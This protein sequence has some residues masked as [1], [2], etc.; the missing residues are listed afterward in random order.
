M[1]V[2]AQRAA[3]SERTF[4]RRFAA[5]TGTT[6]GKWLLAQR[7]HHARTLLESTDLAVETVA[8]RAGFGSAALLRHHFG[9]R[10]A[11]HRRS[12]GVRSAPRTCAPA[13]RRAPLR[14]G[15]MTYPPA[16]WNMHG[17][18]WLSLFRV[19][20]GD[21]PDRPAGVYGAA[22]VSYERPSPLT[23]SE[24]LVAR[25]VGEEGHH[26]RHLG[27]L[28]RLARRRSRP[29]GD[30][31]GP[32]RL[33]PRQRPARRC[34][35]RRGPPASRAV[36]SPG[37]GSPTSPT[38]RCARRSRARPQQE[39]ESG[40][41]GRRHAHGQRQG[42]ALPRPLG[43]QRRRAARL[44]GRQAAP[45]VVPDGRLSDV[46]RLILA[47]DPRSRRPR[48]DSAPPRRRPRGRG[49]RG[50]S[51]SRISNSSV[52]KP[53]IARPM[54]PTAPVMIVVTVPTVCV[55]AVKVSCTASLRISAWLSL[56]RSGPVS[57]GQVSLRP[58]T[59]RQPG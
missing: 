31:E 38:R 35:A 11:W 32:V 48:V 49:R 47:V 50:G 8:S 1:R 23:Y 22:L 34:S 7:L 17:Q 27:G 56:S 25:P 29:L 43:V 2:L 5:E 21:H 9:T 13:E 14:L 55:A 45:R 30:P 26:H 42:A 20:E 12:T 10:S 3:M 19:R 16:P 4:A 54:S 40:E 6:P 58:V 18:L 41:R 28:G 53:P 24:L 37:P 52:A 44:A 39:R 59:L 57:M 33:P 51:E 36:R 46:V 15:A